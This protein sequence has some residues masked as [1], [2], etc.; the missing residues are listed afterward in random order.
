MTKKQGEKPHPAGPVSDALSRRLPRY[1]R[2]LREMEKEGTAYVSSK[3]LAADM[4]LTDSQVRRD[5]SLFGGFGRYGLGYP[6][7][8]LRESLGDILDIRRAHNCV[9]VGAGNIGRA[10]AMYPGFR[11]KGFLISALFDNDPAVVGKVIGGAQVLHVSELKS[12]ASRNKI[13]IAIIAT[14]V[15]CAQEIM[16][17]L[18]SA[19][20]HGIW[21]FVPVDL[22]APPGIEVCNVHLSDSLLA[23]TFRMHEKRVMKHQEEWIGEQPGPDEG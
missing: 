10:V 15:A 17:V 13:E 3:T 11:E 20:V 8:G 23:L 14:P 2:H 7:A 12:Y 16:D 19:H 9:I 21:N 18:A 6:V 22:G 5:L 4:G 1:Y